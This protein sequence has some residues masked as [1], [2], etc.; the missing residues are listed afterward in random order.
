MKEP[1]HG[2]YSL[3]M[4][5]YRRPFSNREAV[6]AA[7]KLGSDTTTMAHYDA[8]Q[9]FMQAGHG[10]PHLLIDPWDNT[11]HGYWEE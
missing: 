10:G 7:F 6:S 2:G 3:S 4:C 5:P 9:C 8:A 1:M 11:V